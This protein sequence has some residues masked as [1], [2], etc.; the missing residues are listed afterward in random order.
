[1]SFIKREF[2]AEYD[3]HVGKIRSR[4]VD[5][6]S[7]RFAGQYSSPRSFARMV[8]GNEFALSGITREL[9]D[10]WQNLLRSLYPAK[11]VMLDIIWV[12]ERNGLKK[13]GL[14]GKVCE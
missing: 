9:Y 1:M 5:M 2:R 12:L 6:L 14:D 3:S 4:L 11:P 13:S 10:A 8:V 7:E